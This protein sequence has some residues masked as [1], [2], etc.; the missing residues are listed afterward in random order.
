MTSQS[1]QTDGL[2]RPFGLSGLLLK[3][4]CKIQVDYPWL[5]CCVLAWSKHQ[6]KKALEVTRLKSDFP[7][8][9]GG[10]ATLAKVVIC[11]TGYGVFSVC[12]KD[13]ESDECSQDGQS[14]DTVKRH[15]LGD[16]F[17]FWAGLPGNIFKAALTG[18]RFTPQNLE[19]KGTFHLQD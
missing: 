4:N 2:R 3:V 11:Y 15:K 1:T 14:L 17:V 10:P 6:E 9:K 8:D 16:S 13:V 19:K 12:G 7:P 18:I 5:Q